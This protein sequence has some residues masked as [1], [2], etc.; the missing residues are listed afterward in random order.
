MWDILPR[1]PIHPSSPPANSMARKV[2][3][4]RALREEAE[5]AEAAEKEAPPKKKAKRK[6]KRKSRTKEAVEVR[7]KLY[8]G[9]YNQSM[10]RVALYEFNQKE[11]AEQKADDLGK[12][13]KSPHFVQRVKE[14]IV[15]E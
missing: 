7:K 9:V 6:T 15:E 8:W 5:A 1:M 4:R 2:V 14:E 12:G 10:K 13:G 3:S 11:A